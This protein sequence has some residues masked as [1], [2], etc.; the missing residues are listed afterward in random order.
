MEHISVDNYE[1]VVSLTFYI[2]HEEIMAIGERLQELNEDAYMNGYNWEAVLNA[3]LEAYCPELLSGL[4]TDPEAGLY[5]AMY[6]T[7]AGGEEKAGHL[8]AIITELINEPEK[9]YSFVSEYGDD[10]QWD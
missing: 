8:A 2:E 1:G 9:L 6:R 5:T 10:I 7:D 4:D 3:Y